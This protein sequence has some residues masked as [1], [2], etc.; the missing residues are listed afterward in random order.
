[1][2]CR[3]CMLIGRSVW[4]YGL[5]LL[6]FAV[7]EILNPYSERYKTFIDMSGHHSDVAT[8]Q[9]DKWKSF[10]RHNSFGAH[11]RDGHVVFRQWKD[12]LG[13]VLQRWGKTAVCRN[14]ELSV[15]RFDDGH[16]V[17]INFLRDC[18]ANV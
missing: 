9:D 16:N 8:P 14:T 13:I 12:H 3:S 4:R 1:M 5:V 17:P 2:S 7:R 6:A 15:V 18:L 10:R 11:T